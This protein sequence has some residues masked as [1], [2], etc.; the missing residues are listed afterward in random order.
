MLSLTLYQRCR[1]VLKSA[2]MAGLLGCYVGLVVFFWVIS[3]SL[4]AV[5]MAPKPQ[6]AQAVEYY[7]MQQYPQSL[8]AFRQLVDSYPTDERLTYYLAIT[9]VQLNQLPEA[10]YYYQQTLQLT[11]Q[12]EIAVLAKEGLAH[13]DASVVAKSLAGIDSPPR[14]KP[15]AGAGSASEAVGV[16]ANGQGGQQAQ[17]PLLNQLLMMQM[18]AGGGGGNGG[19]NNPMGGMLPLL[20]M[21]QQQASAPGKPGE[22]PQGLDPKVMSELMSQSWLNNMDLFNNNNNDNK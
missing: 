10:K 14:P 15:L 17:Q 11:P 3:T 4:L 20:L 13:L 8:Q 5:A 6:Y 22:L 12:G 16:I 7:R 2:V 9:L 21:Q 1:G 19:N 18:M